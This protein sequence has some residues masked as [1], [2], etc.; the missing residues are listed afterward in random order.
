MEKIECPV[1]KSDEF[2]E[3][4]RTVM[5]NGKSSKR[6]DCIQCGKSFSVPIPDKE[7]KEWM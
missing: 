7:S 3:Y 6:Y 1:C 2:V 4:D 5:E